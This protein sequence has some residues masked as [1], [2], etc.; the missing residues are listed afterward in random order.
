MSDEEKTRFEFFIRSHFTKNTIREIMSKKLNDRTIIT[1]EMVI[2]VSGLAKLFVGEI[3]SESIIYM[4][5]DE[6]IN[7][8]FGLGVTIEHV[9]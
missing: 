5:T 2:A 9:E 6:Y 8:I 3:I 1:D 4:K 7:N